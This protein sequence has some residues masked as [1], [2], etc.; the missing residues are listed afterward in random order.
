VC[1]IGPNVDSPVW[2][3]PAFGATTIGEQR[4]LDGLRIRFHQ[5]PCKITLSLQEN[6]PGLAF[7]SRGAQC[8]PHAALKA[9]GMRH[10]LRCQWQHGHVERPRAAP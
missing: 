5:S 1:L 10:R 8:G 4:C 7:G 9:S 2:V 3:Y 6:R